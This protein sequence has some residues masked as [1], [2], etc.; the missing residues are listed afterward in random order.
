MRV[1]PILEDAVTN[2]AERKWVQPSANSTA[3]YMATVTADKTTPTV[4]IQDE[5]PFFETMIALGRPEAADIL[6]ALLARVAPR[7]VESVPL[8]RRSNEL[9]PT[10]FPA[11]AHTHNVNIVL[12]YNLSRYLHRLSSERLKEFF[13]VFRAQQATR[14][15]EPLG[16][17]MTAAMFAAPLIAA[18]KSATLATPKIYVARGGRLVCDFVSKSRRLTVVVTDKHAHLMSATPRKFDDIL[19]VHGSVET[20]KLI[21]KAKKLLSRF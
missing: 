14:G 6:R 1:M 11:A 16:V 15:T 21:N 8:Y 3:T 4:A 18:I 17:S 20:N 2:D 5:E 12:Y 19:A 9:V 13:E 7:N 10:A